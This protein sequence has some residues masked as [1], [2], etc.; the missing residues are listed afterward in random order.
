MLAKHSIKSVSLPPRKIYIYLPPV[1]DAL[2]I[3]TPGVYR[4]PCEC[5]QV[6]I[7]KACRSIPV[8]IKEHIRHIRLAQ[9]EKPAVA[10]HSIKQYHIIKLQVTKLLSAKAGY[11]D[12][13]IR[14]DIELEGS[15]HNMN[16]EDGL[17]LS[18]S[19]KPLLHRL[20][21]RR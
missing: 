9:T 17:V 5:G 8:R 4:I 10:E 16:R 11:I 15:P 2:G 12:R 13:L 20:K 18:K 7:G 3:R 6:Y 19:W 14:E 21:E 1:K